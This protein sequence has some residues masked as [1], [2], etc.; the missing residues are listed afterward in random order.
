MPVGS[1]V[2]VI[3][4]ALVLVGIG[5]GLTSATLSPPAVAGMAIAAVAFGALSATSASP[6]DRETHYH[7]VTVE[8][9]P[10]LPG[11]D[12]HLLLDGDYNSYVNLRYPILLAYRYT[13]WIAAAIDAK[14]PGRDPLDVVFVGGG[15]LTLP[16]WLEE[17]RPGSHSTVLE[18][19][20]EM[21]DF[22]EERT[23]MRSSPRFQV[24][25]G[26]ARVRMLDQESD[27]ADVVVGDAFS[28]L[29][30]P[31]HLTTAEWIDEVQRVL[32]P[33]GLY[34]LNIIDYSPFDFLQAESATLLQAF[35]DV[36][37]V[38]FANR[39]GKPAGNNAVLL[40]SDR[41]LPASVRSRERGALNFL[42]PALESFAA[43]AEPL[44]DDY[45]PVDQLLTIR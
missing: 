35:A 3:G 22:V 28:G 41:P 31:W 17:T 21:V 10:L 27:S 29:T 23:G 26:D 1:A 37:M 4:L 45:A 18:V 43:G 20:G 5:L 9:E 8:A 7:C 25:V 6:C 42:R 32:R 12:F 36:R 38:T 33:G 14:D 19:D 40:A 15:G 30:V 24:D 34:A 16:R 13:R 44:R 11:K 2:L 39:N